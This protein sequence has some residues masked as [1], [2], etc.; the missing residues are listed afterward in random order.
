MPISTAFANILSPSVTVVEGTAG[1]R[2]IEIASHSA[3]YMIGTSSIG[4]VFEPTL[5]LSLEDFQNQFGGSASE[6]SVRLLFRN[7]SQAK[8]FFVKA[9]IATEFAV[10][11]DSAAAGDYS[12][13]INGQTVTYT[14]TVSDDEQEITIALQT[15]INNSTVGAD[16]NASIGSAVNQIIIR[17]ENPED[18]LEITISGGDATALDVTPSQPKASDY[19]AAI[20]NSFDRDEGWA[21]GFI[22]CPEAFQTLSAANDR[23]SVGS[24]MEQLARSEMF[25]WKALIDVGASVSGSA[26]IK[27]EGERYV[28]PKGHTDVFAPYLVDFEGSTVPPSAGIAAMA[29]RMFRE[30]GYHQPYAGDLYPLQGVVDVSRRYGRQE[31]DTLNPSGINLI[32]FLRNRGVCVWGMR[33]R[34]SDSFYRFSTTRVI[35]NVLNGTLRNSFNSE[36]FTSIDD[37]GVLLGR[38]EETALSVCRRMW[39][40]KAF[41]GATATDAFAV[42]C[43]FENN[44]ADDLE[45]G[46]ILLEVYAAPAPNLEKLL[47]GVYRTGVGQVQA[48]AA[49]GNSRA[50]R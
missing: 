4:D 12:L 9:G 1:Y 29:T 49:S 25:D 48:A 30:R 7:D 37:G 2:V 5:C 33:T 34:S 44:E 21:Q 8:M 46:Q 36:I 42:K 43:N 17:A 13:S 50:G 39:Q 10:T 38:I 16:V 20:E 18:S 32:R 19:I 47:I 24:A 3:I 31:Q 27:E 26:A 40:G 11:I 14:A 35:F 23:L 41:F 6:A 28:S 45:L 15:A 22:I